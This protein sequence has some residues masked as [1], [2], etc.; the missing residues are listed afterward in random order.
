MAAD[1]VEASFEKFA[2][3]KK[4]ETVKAIPNACD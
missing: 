3:L 4:K 2:C 1:E